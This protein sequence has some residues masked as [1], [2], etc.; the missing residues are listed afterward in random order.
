[1][2]E[3]CTPPKIRQDKHGDDVVTFTSKHTLA[4]ICRWIMQNRGDAEDVY[5]MLG[6]MLDGVYDK[7]VN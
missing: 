7:P 3:V 1:M 5:F 4:D 6:Q 2:A